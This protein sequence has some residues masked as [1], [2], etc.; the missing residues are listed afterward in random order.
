MDLVKH[1]SVATAA[2]LLV[3]GSLSAQQRTT[4]N[5][6]TQ[7]PT[8]AQL[9]R[10]EDAY[11]RRQLTELRRTY[12]RDADWAN[13]GDRCNPGAL[14]IFPKDT[15]AAQRDSLQRLV[16]HIEQT[17]IAR[18]AGTSVDTPDG[19][20]LLRVIVGWEAGIDRPHWDSDDAAP[21][22]AIATG[23][24]GE[25]PDPTGD[26]CLK[27]IELDTVTF[28]IPAFTDMTFPR[29]PDVRV[30]AYFGPD[31]IS[32]ARNEFAAQN[33]KRP[34]AELQY[35]FVS[36]FVMWQDWAVVVVTRP[37]EL[38]GVDVGRRNNGGAVYLMH[39]VANEWRLLSILRSWGS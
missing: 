11:V 2:L 33:L 38:R 27:A 24:T 1:I 26:G 22:Q 39:K 17:I 18:G 3:A 13:L 12:L 8:D 10:N 35:I 19:R 34:D 23:L 16:N 14:R 25:Y 30:K 5:R 4:A 29:S 6:T 21:R 7:S 37:V 15:S 9:L 31:A 28:V 32:H 36:P 20:A